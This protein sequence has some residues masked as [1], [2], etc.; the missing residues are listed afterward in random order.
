MEERSRRRPGPRGDVPAVVLAAAEELL[1]EGPLGQLTVKD[2]IARA[3]V[4]RGSFYAHFASLEAVVVALI[5]QIFD[6]LYD[7]ARPY[8]ELVDDGE[9]EPALRQALAG[10]LERWRRHPSAF[11]A[12]VESWQPEV[13]EVWSTVIG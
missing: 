6:E 7:A 12:A 11:R 1:A 5:G 13:R 9:P 4:A 10:S 3:G 8:V 2:L